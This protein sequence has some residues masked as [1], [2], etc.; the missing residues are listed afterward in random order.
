MRQVA[1]RGYYPLS[2]Q[3][4]RFRQQKQNVNTNWKEKTNKNGVYVG[5]DLRLSCVLQNA[6][7]RL[8]SFLTAVY[9]SY[10]SSVVFRR[11]IFTTHLSQTNSQSVQVHLLCTCP[12]VSEDSVLLHLSLHEQLIETLH[13]LTCVRGRLVTETAGVCLKGIGLSSPFTLLHFTLRNI[14]MHMY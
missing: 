1:R 14:I 5:L 4:C 7:I 12:S 10:S 13:S 8:K 11:N 6:C 3:P 9:S 2:W